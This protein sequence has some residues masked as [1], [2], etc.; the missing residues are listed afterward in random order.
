MEFKSRSTHYLIP[1]FF[2]TLFFLYFQQD[3][4]EEFSFFFYVSGPTATCPI[5]SGRGTVPATG[6]V[7]V[8]SR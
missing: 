7:V 8:G 4:R 6:D 5:G 2:I 3:F 1:I